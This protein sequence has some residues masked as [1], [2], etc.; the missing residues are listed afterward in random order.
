MTIKDTGNEQFN[1]K[2]LLHNQIQ[3]G[4][5]TKKLNNKFNDLYI[6]SFDVWRNAHEEL[7]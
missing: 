7:F 2:S 5:S 6:F 1:Q 3:L 4:N